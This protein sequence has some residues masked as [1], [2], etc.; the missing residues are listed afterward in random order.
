MIKVDKGNVSIE[1]N[2]IDIISEFV[3]LI[4]AMDETKETALQEAGASVLGFDWTLIKEI[5]K[6]LRQK[7]GELEKEVGD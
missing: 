3:A 6:N 7:L 4:L 1:G 2:V 5:A